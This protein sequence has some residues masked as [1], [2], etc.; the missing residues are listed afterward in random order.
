M[1]RKLMIIG[2]ILIFAVL[3][4]GVF[5]I[6]IISSSPDRQVLKFAKEMNKHC[7]MMIDAVTRLD[8][9]NALSDNSLHFNYTLMYHDK[10]SLIIENLKHYM[11]PMILKKIKTSSVLSKYI[12]K[13]ITWIYSY[14]DKDGDFIFKLIYTPEQLK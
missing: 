11:E 3:S 14:N 7:P 6:F 1:N 13:N 8:K 4:I 12:K 5:L 9:V 10:D 2:A